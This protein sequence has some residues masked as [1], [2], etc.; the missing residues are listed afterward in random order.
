MNTHNTPSLNLEP[1]K[2][3][4]QYIFECSNNKKYPSNKMTFLVDG[5][6]YRV[7]YNYTPDSLNISFNSSDLFRIF[8]KVIQE[9]SKEWTVIFK[10]WSTDKHKVYV[11][12][13]TKQE[14]DLVRQSIASLS[15]EIL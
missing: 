7:S 14:I 1:F 6:N 5:I 8:P 13:S 2:E 9:I 10:F 15:W 3:L 4:L 11:T 12:I